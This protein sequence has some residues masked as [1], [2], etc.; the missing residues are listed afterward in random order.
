MGFW[1]HLY[2]YKDACGKGAQMSQF[3][4][5]LELGTEI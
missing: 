2:K 3:L 5:T 1:V 4:C